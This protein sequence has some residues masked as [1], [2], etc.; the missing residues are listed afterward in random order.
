MWPPIATH[1]IAEMT[2]HETS[3][4]LTFRDVDS[5]GI[6]YYARYLFLFEMGRVEWM[7]DEGFSYRDME[8]DMKLSLPVTRADCRYL[9]PL[10]YD[11]IAV[12]RTEIAAWTRT[13]LC[14]SHEVHRKA[15]GQFCAEG[16][17][18]LGC[19]PHG[20]RKPV[21]LPDSLIGVLEN[22]AGDKKGRLRQ[23]RALF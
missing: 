23:V 6:L 16:H 8:E 10:H 9:A 15:L 18:E 11:D 7:R 19:L 12:V 5:M 3:Y 17:V 14:F 21:A 4:R 22:R 13:T 20:E 2:A 1:R